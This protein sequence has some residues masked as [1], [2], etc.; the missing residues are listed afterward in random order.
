MMYTDNM[1]DEEV[2]RILRKKRKRKL[3]RRRIISLIVA[4]AIAVGGGYLAGNALGNKTYADE[5]SKV[6]SVAGDKPIINVAMEQLGNKGG[7]PFWSW[8]GF[9]SRE[10]W[11]ACF[12]SWCADQCGYIDAG[13]V[14]K[15]SWCD[16]GI[17]WFKARGQWRDRSYLPEPGTIIF[18]D[19]DSDGFSDHVGIVEYCDGTYVYTIEGNTSGD[20]CK[21]NVYVVGEYDIAGYGVY[22]GT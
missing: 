12:V 8:Y 5:M 9:N 16:T 1:T 11:C 20:M 14:P 3:A 17:D 4:A 19:W 6:V 2:R 15:F 7:E 21:Q 18:F 10:E 22:A 13:I